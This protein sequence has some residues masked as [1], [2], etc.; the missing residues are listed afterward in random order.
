M[1]MH[2]VSFLDDGYLR[3]GRAADVIE[4]ERSDARSDDIMDAFKRG[5]FAGELDGPPVSY[6]DERNH[7]ARWLHMEITVPPCTLPS[8]GAALRV[9]PKD[10]YGVNH[11]TIASVLLCTNALPGER[12]H[13]ERLFDYG[14]PDYDPELPYSTL[15]A[16][17]FRDFPERGRRELEALLAP[18]AK[19]A[20][21]L[22]RRGMPILV[23]LRASPVTRAE[24]DRGVHGVTNPVSP[25]AEPRMQMSR[26]ARRPYLSLNAPSAGADRN[27]QIAKMEVSQ[28]ST[29]PA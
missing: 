1:T 9:L 24:P 18:K 23:T 2:Q 27:W 13:W 26:M 11:S 6:S 22:A 12:A 20:T 17:P 7:P 4:R 8:I 19:L 25:I 15:A 5:I 3:L 10:L 28:P 29:M 21:W 14:A 16:I